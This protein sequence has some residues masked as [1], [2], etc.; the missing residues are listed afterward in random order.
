[1]AHVSPH[2]HR[3]AG[4]ERDEIVARRNV[5]LGLWAAEELGLA[6]EDAEFYA[7][8]VHFSDL[9]EPGHDDVVRKLA[10]DFAAKGRPADRWAIRR[11]L[12]AMHARAEAGLAS[13]F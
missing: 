12:H 2:S 10:R 3:K 13:P 9:G 6:G 5:L 7:W 11:R 4:L 1:M 8:G